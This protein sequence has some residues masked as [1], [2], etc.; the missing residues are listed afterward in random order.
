MIKSFLVG[1]QNR[2]TSQVRAGFATN[3]KKH[4]ARF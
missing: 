2:E 3:E 1:T 4:D